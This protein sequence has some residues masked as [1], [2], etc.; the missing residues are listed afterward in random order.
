MPFRN[1]L[2]ERL[3]RKEAVY[4][5]WVTL[6]SASVTEIAATLGLG[7][8]VV[9]MEHGH[10]DFREVMDHLRAARGSDTAVLV[11]VPG[12]QASAVKRVLDLGAHG[13]ILPL[14]RGAEDVRRGLSY[15][16]YPPEGIRG[17]GGERA[18]LWGL[19][20]EGY[21]R[22]ANRETMIVPLME[23]REAIA[24][25]DAILSVPGIEAIFFGPA[26]LSAS[27]GYTG[28]WEGTGVADRILDVR[29]RAAARG[30]ASGIMS[31]GLTDLIRR[32]DQGFHLIG[33]GSDTTLL[34]RSLR[35]ALEAAAAARSSD[36]R[37]AGDTRNPGVTP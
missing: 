26:D 34:I 2:L 13:V 35:D 22:D 16:R 3:R 25:T 5:L 8:I 27:L 17:I 7:W 21:L 32:R 24:E 10:L 37:K 12:I 15:G 23:T 18:V 1:P 9:E 6:E 20:F 29:A 4:G 14:V 33:L 19:D 31:R 36:E 28:Q 11:R 30:I